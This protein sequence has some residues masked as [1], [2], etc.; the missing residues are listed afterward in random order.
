MVG[1]RRREREVA[2]TAVELWCERAPLP[3]N[4][5]AKVADL[6]RG[7]MRVGDILPAASSHPI[8]L[9]DF[10]LRAPAQHIHAAFALG[11]M[12]SLSNPRLLLARLRTFADTIVFSYGYGAN[13][14]VKRLWRGNHTEA[15]ILNFALD[16]GYRVL[17][18]KEVRG[19]LVVLACADQPGLKSSM[20]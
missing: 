15:E 4:G 1:I 11:V 18:S 17:G 10:D 12:D 16:T 2:A 13:S 19:R 9:I 7:D 20:R 14:G 6:G 8:D 3:L 5:A